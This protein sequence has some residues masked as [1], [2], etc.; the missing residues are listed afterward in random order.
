MAPVDFP[1][2]ALNFLVFLI[3]L[4]I[5][6]SWHLFKHTFSQGNKP[7]KRIIADATFRWI[8]ITQRIP[9]I[10]TLVGPGRRTY[11]S[12]C[13]RNS[14]EPQIEDIKAGAQLFWIAKKPSGRVILYLHGGGFALPM[15]YYSLKFWRYVQSK[16]VDAGCEVSIA[17]LDYTLVP[18]AHFPVPL[19][20]T[21]A[22]LNH[23]L[24]EGFKPEDIQLLLHMAHPLDGIES[25]D[26]GIKL[27]GAYL[28]SPWLYLIPR[29]GVQSYLENGGRD[30]VASKAQYAEF[31][32]GVLGGVKRAE[33]LAYL[34]ASHTPPSWYRD[35][36]EVADRVLITA[37][38]HECLRDDIVEFG[39]AFCEAHGNAKL[40]VD[41]C[42][43]HDDPFNDFM[44][45]EEVWAELTPAIVQWFADG[46]R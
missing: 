46:F 9:F 20:Q 16:L 22:A 43:I 44:L 30:V 29:D 1:R 35:V 7:W 24:T 17:I 31:G 19:V 23:L 26:P 38:G 33:D 14:I 13:N 3:V 32:A 18:E 28:M 36:G 8:V 41:T 5:V 2:N 40:L 39:S 42:G 27:R 11:I 12:W 25:L 15:G 45:G 21:V 6:L 10:A 4:P 37:G 34:E